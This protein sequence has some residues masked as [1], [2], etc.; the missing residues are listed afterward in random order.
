MTAVRRIDGFAWLA[1]PALAYLG[2]LYA[3]PLALLLF[4]SLSAGG[5]FPQFIAQ[6]S[7][8]IKQLFRLI[9]PHPLFEHFE[10]F[11][12]RRELGKR[13]LMRAECA[14]NL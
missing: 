3:L 12:V 5:Q 1:A 11:W 13:D 7:V 4:K 9:A 6:R 8:F 14:F 2:L 10:V